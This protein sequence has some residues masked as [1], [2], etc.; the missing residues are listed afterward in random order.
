MSVGENGRITARQ[1]L[2]L[3]CFK[4]LAL[5]KGFDGAAFDQYISSS[6]PKHPLGEF[7]RRHEEARRVELR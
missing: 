5:G 3:F 6:F 2:R 1:T 7:F 4:F